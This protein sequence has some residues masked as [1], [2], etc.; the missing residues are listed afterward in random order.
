MKNEY[1]VPAPH[2]YGRNNA[3]EFLL[4][5]LTTPEKEKGPFV[6][7]ASRFLAFIHE[8]VN[9]GVRTKKK[10]TLYDTLFRVPHDAFVAV[11]DS[12]VLNR[13]GAKQRELYVRI[14]CST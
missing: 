10:K 14:T 13:V 8:S 9:R 2:N 6:M 1:E 7:T 3:T 12:R 11:R 5:A 4:C